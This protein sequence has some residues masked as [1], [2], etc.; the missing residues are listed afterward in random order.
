MTLPFGI[1]AIIENSLMQLLSFH[2][3]WFIYKKLTYSQVAY[4]KIAGLALLGSILAIFNLGSFYYQ[5]VIFISLALFERRGQRMTIEASLFFGSYAVIFTDLFARFAPLYV[6]DNLLTGMSLSAIQANSFLRFLSYVLI[7][8]TFLSINYISSSDIDK[9]KELV[10]SRGRERLLVIADAIL[11]VYIICRSILTVVGS[12]GRIFTFLAMVVYLLMVTTL[13]RQSHKLMQERSHEAL[14]I[15]INN[16]EVYNKHIEDLY[17]RVKPVQQDFENLLLALEEP[18]AQNQLTEVLAVYHNHLEQLNLSSLELNDKLSVLFELPYAELRSWIVNQIIPLEQKGVTVNLHLN[19]QH[20]PGNLK[21]AELIEVLE[22]C[23]RLSEYLWEKESD[24][25]ISL[26]IDQKT[27]NQLR[28]I[29]GNTNREAEYEL[30]EHLAISRE[31]AKFCWSNGIS[32]VNE[33]EL[34][35]TFQIVTVG[36]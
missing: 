32:L 14:T 17:A 30:D 33:K 2:V 20:Y 7:Y 4:W 1:L 35:K 27:D 31:L 8:P 23:F 26:E 3:T 25:S 15:Y 29:F 10:Y 28:F 11:M 22:R 5:F 18:L 36:L 12:E 24:T 6:F 13:N 9:I 34:F 19:V 16:L 21:I